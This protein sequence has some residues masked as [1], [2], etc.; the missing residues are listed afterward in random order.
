MHLTCCSPSILWDWRLHSW[1]CVWTTQGHSPGPSSAGQLPLTIK[2]SRIQTSPFLTQKEGA[3]CLRMGTPWCNLAEHPSNSLRCRVR[4]KLEIHLPSTSCADYL[5][6]M[7]LIHLHITHPG[8]VARAMWGPKEPNESFII[9]L[10]Q[11]SLCWLSLRAKKLHSS[12]P[13]TS[14]LGSLNS[15][16]SS[17]LASG[18]ICFD[19]E[20]QLKNVHAGSR[21][22]DEWKITAVKVWTLRTLCSH[23]YTTCGIQPHRRLW[24]L[25]SLGCIRRQYLYLLFERHVWQSW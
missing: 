15:R 1:P 19:P 25:C 23:H 20:G 17:D 9:F 11:V 7:F 6:H 5:E 3:V 22:W 18:T 10:K 14:K 8:G 24:P 12:R 21:L 16:A 2:V 13:V 4:A